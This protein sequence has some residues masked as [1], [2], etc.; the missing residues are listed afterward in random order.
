MLL[1]EKSK[2]T[3][4]TTET[5]EGLFD[6]RQN[7]ANI[8]AT[9]ELAAT[10]PVKL[11]YFMQRYA[12]FNSFAGSLVARLSS[13]IG[14]SYQLFRDPQEG[15][16]DQSDRGLEIAAK[17][18]AATVDE[19]NDGGQKVPHRTLAQVTLKAIADYAQLGT[20]QCNHIAQTPDWMQGVIT[21]LI[22]GYQGKIDDLEAL[23]TAVGFHIGSELLADREYS[24]IDKVIRYSHRQQGFD[25]WL[26]GKQVEIGGKRMS[27][28]YWIVVHGKHNDTGV[29]AEHCDFAIEA[30]NL[31][32]QYSSVS[33]EQIFKWASKGFLDFANVQQRLFLGTK[34]ELE[35]LSPSQ[36]VTNFAELN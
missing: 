23:A 34:A 27:P 10:N 22:A 30:L 33:P 21:D 1:Q 12:Y 4:F 17:V 28:W 20:P 15:N 7:E 8:E 14:I 36:V 25:A 18:F 9:V 13:A 19:H 16:I 11:Y 2:T 29:E 31:M 32:A 3:L 24:L 35:A 6:R 5:F 26:Q